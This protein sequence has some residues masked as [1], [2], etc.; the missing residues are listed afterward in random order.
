MI[1]LGSSLFFEHPD[2][3][4]PGRPPGNSEEPFGFSYPKSI[5]SCFS[6]TKFLNFTSFSHSF[7]DLFTHPEL[8][9]AHD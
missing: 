1:V 9:F 5:L 3:S 8:R 4:I 2:K 7:H 6:S